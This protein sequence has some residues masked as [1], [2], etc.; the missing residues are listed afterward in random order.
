VTPGTAARPVRA[1]VLDKPG[2]PLRVETLLLDPPAAGEVLVRLEASG[3]CHS[4]LHVA[5]GEWGDTE[6]IVLGHEGCGVVEE[7][8]PGADP[9]LR[10]RRVVLNWFAPCLS[11]PACQRGRQWECSG[12]KALLN[13]L[14]DGSTRMHRDGGE[15][16]LPCLGIATFGEW[17]VVPAVAAVPVPDQIDPAVAALIGC[18]VSTGLGAV[19]KTAEVRPGATVA[20]YGLGGVGL[21][22]VM[23]AA[24][25]GAHTIVAVDRS[26]EKLERATAV[27]ATAGVVAGDDD[28]ETRAAV[29]D[30]T[31]GGAE[32]AFEAIGLQRTIDLTI[33]S[34]RTGGTAVLVGMTPFGVRGSFDA[35][36]L[37]DRSVRI[38]GSNYGFTVGALDFPRYA[39][40]HLA[41]RLPIEQLVERRIGLED[42]EDAFEAMRRGEGA[43]R[44]IVHGGGAISFF[45]STA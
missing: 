1:A 37:V 28:D 7:V 17:T 25:A 11:C 42:V 15:D 27:G 44:V 39:A 3:V 20:V 43:R 23:G 4:D 24:F 13:R 36:D 32:F 41:G 31:A 30:A 33:R 35:Y 6:P 10:G 16:V 5:D 38:L 21:S 18:C 14:P 2:T 29:L 9:A 45:S 19:V 34:V 8:G 26:A 12:S 40:L 22:I